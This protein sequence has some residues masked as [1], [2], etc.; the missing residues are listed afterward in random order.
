MAELLDCGAFV[1]QDAGSALLLDREPVRWEAGDERG[2]GWIEGDVR[3]PAEKL[4]HWRA[5]AEAGVCG[6]VFDGRRRSLHSA[7]N[8]L[9]PLYWL[10]HGGAV[11]FASRIDPLVQTSPVRLSVD[12]EAWASILTI[13]VPGGDRT[14]FA[15]VR[16][17]PQHSLLRRRFRS[18]RVREERW[19]WAEVETDQSAR[20]AAEGLA[21]ALDKTLAPL[22]GEIVCPLSG[23]RDSRMLFAALARDG[24]VAA[25][26]T[27]SDDEGEPREEEMAAP[28][29]AAFGVPHERLL[30]AEADYPGQWE[31]RAR[32][33]EYQ[34][35]D[36]AW[37]VPVAERVA[38]L[39]TPIPDGFA[40]DVLLSGGPPYYKQEVLDTSDPR[41]STLAMFEMLR[42][43]GHA[44][45]A[46]EESFQEPVV[47]SA[48]EQY[49]A[50]TRRFEGHPLQNI[51][52]FYAT[53][54]RRG[55]S[56]NPTQLFGERSFALTPGATDAFARAA[57][58]THSANKAGGGLYREVFEILEP[59]IAA[60]P[61]TA[62]VPRKPP[63]LPRRWCSPT[64]L[65][66]HRRSLLDGPLTPHLSAQLRAW[67]D[68]PAATEPDPH[69]R[70]GIESV[71]LLHAWWRR[72][73]DQLRDVDPQQLRA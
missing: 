65:G 34:L 12:W 43:W 71:D 22:P 19:P 28:V 41:A 57:L 6:L 7:V 18:W 54:T 53:R 25:A 63:H 42:H 45:V 68:A 51:L 72:Y 23:G 8:G 17:L 3:R 52:G 49:L 20:A 59:R 47:A 69:L 58:S 36:H 21:T 29:A 46:L 70:L 62:E 66:F 9:G 1:H 4:P 67:I 2:L 31:E 14:P 11:Y 40:M 35:V 44:H 60:L 50:A 64:A 56:T 38:G 16:R 13:R 15:E 48:R 27:V 30:G 5:A 26:V 37:L 61:A 33:A 10:E 73:R 24:R 32:R 39:P 55:V